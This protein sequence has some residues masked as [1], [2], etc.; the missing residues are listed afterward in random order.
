MVSHYEQSTSPPRCQSV[1]QQVPSR[2]Y[3]RKAAALLFPFLLLAS[4][5]VSTA[6]L[7]QQRS[8]TVGVL[9]DFP[10]LHMGENG[11]PS[12]ILGELLTEVAKEEG[13]V[14][15]AVPCAWQDCLQ[16]LQDGQI[17]L[18]PDVARNHDRELR[19]DFHQLP[20]LHS[21]SQ[22]YGPDD[23]SI[24]SV[25]DLQNKRVAILA[26]SIQL[27]YL[28]SMASS[29]GIHTNLLEVDQFE[30]GF[31]MV[32]NGQADAVVANYHFG[33]LH[34]KEYRLVATPVIF[35]P[36]QMYYATGKGHHRHLLNAIDKHLAAWQAD[37]G[38]RYFNILQRWG[39]PA[40]VPHLPPWLWWAL[41]ALGT[42]L[43]GALGIA[44]LL[45][46]Q[47]ARQTRHLQASEAKLNTILDSVD[48]HIYIKDR[49]LKYRYGNRKVCEF[50][51]LDLP[52]LIDRSDDQLIQ[53]EGLAETRQSELRV[54]THGERVAQEED[55]TLENG[56]TRT[57]FSIK[58][59][60]RNNK[61]AIESLCGISTDVTEHKA[62]RLAAHQLAFYD[63]L[64][65]LP[66]RRLLLERMDHAL[67]AI[68]RGAGFASVLFID[69]DHF[70][71]INDSSSH[72]TGDTLLCDAAQRLKNEV[73]PQ[74][75]IAR[76]GGDEFVILL[77]RLGRTQQE[78]ART[79]MNIAESVRG[80]LAQPFMIDGQDYLCGASIGVT[81]IQPDGKSAADVLREA[82][83]AMSRS[84]ESGRNQ[85][86]FYETRMQTDLQE[87]LTL[88]RELAQ[89]IGTDQFQLYI[90]AQYDR[91]HTIV[92]AEL[93]A[94]WHHPT[95]G[96]VS[97]SRF[98]PVAEDTGLILRIG[99]WVLQQ[100]C[101]IIK[102]LEQAGELYPLSI[103]VSPRQFRQADFVTRVREILQETGAPPERLIFEV[104]EGILIED[105]Q[106]AADRM[107]ELAGIG[108]RFSI[109]DF[110]TGYSNLS[111][112]KRLPL[113]ELKID[114]C[115]VHDAQHGPDN[116]AI[117]ELILAV[118]RKLKLHVVAEGVETQTQA[119]FLIAQHCDAM[120]GYLFAR[121][122]PIAQWLARHPA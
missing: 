39:K 16:A 122:A 113:Y 89:A 120:Q 33:E 49:Q 63:T 6:A 56:S 96:A 72:A 32:A 104:T 29:F 102:Q 37:P 51:G 93:L 115:F 23:G 46:T 80:A 101:Q 52:D 41:S 106:G 88:E 34:A 79:A 111:Y 40:P 28:K 44:T 17:D 43:L 21:W 84:K 26:A 47:V 27:D 5:F 83:T 53:H 99:D 82:D 8:F 94:R 48:A 55:V 59:P 1:A 61:G 75:T 10:K 25:L 69:L 65:K 50:F 30:T 100:A 58:I 24:N 9:E 112:L 86:A 73:C 121:P 3:F 14:L 74:S 12:G 92:G 57:Y 90:Q 116:A 45:K 110:G 4:F 36:I 2:G 54:I 81:L 87:R 60:L 15:R 97:P 22:I 78:A 11:Q 117:V 38:S 77:E 62:A 108:I 71:R 119:D 105:L 35:Q 66:N 7:S 68:R 91:S 18:L 114:K 76:L 95:L 64:T 103:N 118:A 31:Q 67:D 85:V 70:K 98:I 107:I 13:W 42:L 109:D 20:A 19:Y